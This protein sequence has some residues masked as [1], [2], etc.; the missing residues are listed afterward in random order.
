MPG[1]PGYFVRDNGTIRKPSGEI[2]C[3]G[4]TPQGYH[5]ISIKRNRKHRTFRVH[6]LVAQAFVPNPRPDLFNVVDHINHD[7]SDNRACNLRWLDNHLNMMNRG[8]ECVTFRYI[9][10]KWESQ[11][12][13]MPSKFFATREEAVEHAAKLKKLRFERAYQEK[14]NAPPKTRSFGTQ[15]EPIQS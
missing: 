10:Q 4:V 3:G 15:T 11:V 14:L 2:M 6:R 12:K 1:Y 13:Y 9:T 5:E 8:D 7:R